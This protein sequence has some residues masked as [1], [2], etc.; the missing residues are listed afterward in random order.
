MQKML[1]Y[2][3]FIYIKAL[4]MLKVLYS[5]NNMFL[6]AFILFVSLSYLPIS[7]QGPAS[8]ATAAFR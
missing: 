2:I 5:L 8:A 3:S 4:L 1:K 7:E 6:I